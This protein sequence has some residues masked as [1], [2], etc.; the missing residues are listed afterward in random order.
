MYLYLSVFPQKYKVCGKDSTLSGKLL[1]IYFLIVFI[2]EIDIKNIYFFKTVPFKT[3]IKWVLL[4]AEF[5]V[6]YNQ[7]PTP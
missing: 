3:T 7:D 4:K 2:W 6:V 5:G 1:K